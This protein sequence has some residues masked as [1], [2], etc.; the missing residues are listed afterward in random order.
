M[1]EKV[2]VGQKVIFTSLPQYSCYESHFGF[3]L[4]T[5]FLIFLISFIVVYHLPLQIKHVLLYSLLLLLQN[6]PL[7]LE[8]FDQLY[9]VLPQKVKLLLLLVHKGFWPLYDEGLGFVAE[10]VRLQSLAPLADD[11][12]Q[13]VIADVHEL[14][15]LLLGQDVLAQFAPYLFFSLFVLFI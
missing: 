13:P 1:N 15:R 4:G 8:Q 2:E 10:I 12:H 7:L 11:P 14:P 5:E 3:F 9:L 6:H